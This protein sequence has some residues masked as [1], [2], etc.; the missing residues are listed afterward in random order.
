MSPAKSPSGAIPVDIL[1]QNDTEAL[2]SIATKSA[3]SIAMVKIKQEAKCLLGIERMVADFEAL[4]IARG[5]LPNGAYEVF[6]RA[7]YQ[8]GHAWLQLQQQLT[9]LENA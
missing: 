9:Q 3:Q 7:Y 8:I 2:L 6:E 1:Q 5:R 4:A